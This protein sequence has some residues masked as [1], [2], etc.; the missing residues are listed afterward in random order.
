MLTIPEARMR[1]QE[2]LQRYNKY[3]DDKSFIGNEKQACQSLIVPLIHK[4]LGLL[5]T[6]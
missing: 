4:I 5:R 3:K 1:L 6:A 2:L